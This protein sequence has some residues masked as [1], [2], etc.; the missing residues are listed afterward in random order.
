MILEMFTLCV[1]AAT[2]LFSRSK[3]KVL[4]TS[5]QQ[6][7]TLRIGRWQSLSV[8]ELFLYNGYYRLILILHFSQHTSAGQ[9]DFGGKIHD[10]L[11]KVWSCSPQSSKRLDSIVESLHSWQS[12]L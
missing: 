5:G 8:T 9:L 7:N 12:D 11:T 10:N 2:V 4:R 1:Y 3:P 6:T